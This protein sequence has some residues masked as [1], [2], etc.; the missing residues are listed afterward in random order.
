[1]P[2]N[3]SLFLVDFKS[4]GENPIFQLCFQL[5]R[6]CHLQLKTSLSIAK[7]FLQLKNEVLN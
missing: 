1:M 7:C 5:F 2:N 6:N 3:T 4:L